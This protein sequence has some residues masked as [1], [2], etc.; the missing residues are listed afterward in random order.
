MKTARKPQQYATRKGLCVTAD[1]FRQV[2]AIIRA[3]YDLTPEIQ[4]EIDA[5]MR[6]LEKSK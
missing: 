6:R 1:R 2:V 5:L 3:D 4:A